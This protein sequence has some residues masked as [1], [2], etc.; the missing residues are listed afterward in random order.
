MTSMLIHPARTIGCRFI[1]QLAL[2]AN[3]A[4]FRAEASHGWCRNQESE[5][6]RRAEVGSLV[7]NRQAGEQVFQSDLRAL[8]GEA[9]A[10]GRFGIRG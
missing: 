6:K 9:K 4:P 3:P 8:G 10:A 2:A 7:T 5:G 1:G